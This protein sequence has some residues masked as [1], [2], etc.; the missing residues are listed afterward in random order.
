MQYSDYQHL[1]TDGSKDNERV[2][3][4][5]VTDTHS[6]SVRIPGCSSIVAAEAKTIVL[7]LDIIHELSLHNKCVIFSDSLSVLQAL[8]YTI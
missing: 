5:V 1:Y 4:V 7:A 8:N 2:G 6:H 3:C